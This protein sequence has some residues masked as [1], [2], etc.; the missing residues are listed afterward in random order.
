M[1]ARCAFRTRPCH[2]STAQSVLLDPVDAPAFAGSLLLSLFDPVL[3][4]VFDSLFSEVD[5]VAAAEE[6]SALRESVR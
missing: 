3:L 5:A 2:L 4:S 6:L 1:V